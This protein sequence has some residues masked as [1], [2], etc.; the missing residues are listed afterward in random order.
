MTEDQI[1]RMVN[2][3]LMWELPE[4]FRPDGGIHFEA[5][6]NEGTPLE[7]RRRPVGTNLL[8]ASQAKAM[9]TH[10]VEGLLPAPEAPIL[11]L[12]KA[13]PDHDWSDLQPGQIGWS[14]EADGDGWV[15]RRIFGPDALLKG[16]AA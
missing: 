4:D 2:R 12:V 16:G 8:T 10:M 1:T 9:V 15:V 11:A 7:H 14:V 3:F 13:P 5:I 6:G